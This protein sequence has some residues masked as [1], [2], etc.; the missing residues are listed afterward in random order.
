MAHALPANPRQRDFDATT[1]AD[2]ALVLDPL[3]F[4]TRAFPI[5]GGTKD[6]L[7]EQTTFFRFE[8]SVIDRLGIFDFAFA[9]LPHRVARGNANRYL[10]KTYGAFFAH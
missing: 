8:S 6:S 9:P 10:I 5:P 1:I 2:Y 4:A 7:A 3:V